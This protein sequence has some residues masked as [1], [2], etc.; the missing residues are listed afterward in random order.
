MNINFKL[1]NYINKDGLS[2]LYMHITFKERRERIPLNLFVLK[3]NWDKSKMRLTAQDSASADV[4]LILDNIRSRITK[5]KTYY[6]LSGKTL[7]ID[8]FLI[9]FRRDLPRDN[10]NSFFRATLLDRAST[11]KSS[12]FDKEMAILNKLDDYKKEIA[13]NEL[14][15]EFFLLF[16]N[17]LARL[18]NKR[19]T[20][21]GNIKII[22]K[23][24]RYA[25]KFG[26][27]LPI[28]IDD[29]K[30]GSTKGNKN[31]LN[32]K[33]IKK[34]SSYYFSEHIPE[35]HKIALGYFLFSCFT[36]LRFSDVMQQQRSVLAEGQ[37]TFKHVKTGKNQTV[38]L[39]R[40]AKSII[41][42][43]DQLFLKK[44]SNT[45]IRNL[46]KE[47]CAFL[48]INK[49]VDYHMSRHSF[50]TNYILLGGEVT[51]LQNLMNHSDI[52]ETMTY[53][54][55]AELE[56]NAESDIMDQLI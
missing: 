10:F 24:M 31:Y 33:E 34:C 48:R 19:T 20:R 23:Y 17:H 28:A 2:P 32:A 5:I 52:R 8:N 1:R 49:K 29:I 41:E 38:K 7:T 47:I 3:K 40:T 18:G 11:I 25:I 4:N 42:N 21:N 43:C 50:G 13:F 51:R 30:A 37:F 46:V 9:E 35:N 54:H 36:G 44:Y 53:V 14:D 56:K 55:L 16:R 6:R 39:N 15:E 27:N 26:V 12:T 45:Y 22:K